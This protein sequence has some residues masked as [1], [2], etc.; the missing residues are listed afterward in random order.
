MNQLTQDILLGIAA[1]DALGAPVEFQNPTAIDLAEVASNYSQHPNRLTGFGTWEK[2][3]GTYTDDT[4]MSL[5]TAEFLLKTP[6]HTTRLMEIYAKWLYEGHWTADGDVFDVGS[7]TKKAIDN[8]SRDR[9]IT[10][11]GPK[12]IRSNGNGALM[13]ILPILSFAKEVDSHH[14]Y[15][16]A[17]K[18][19]TCTHGHDIAVDSSFLYLEV[20]KQIVHVKHEDK[21]K[22]LQLLQALVGINSIAHIFTKFWEEDFLMDRLDIQPKGYVVDTLEV[23]IH[24]FITTNSYKEAVLKAIS[25]GHDTDTNAAITGGLAA[26]YYGHESIPEEWLTHLKRKDEIIELAKQ[27]D[28][29]YNQGDFKLESSC[30]GH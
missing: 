28:H 7:T 6:P 2:P 16:I 19:T 27:V 13:R 3:I 10:T 23:A 1:A 24:S 21:T 12:D 26:I 11:C 9:D 30:K 15:N 22:Y 20:A 29:I 8:Y 5:C 4:A 25:Y 17:H 14:L 18:M